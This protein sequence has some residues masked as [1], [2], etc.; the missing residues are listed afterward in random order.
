VDAALRHL[1]A[2]VLLLAPPLLL[3]LR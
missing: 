1:C 2:K 3:V